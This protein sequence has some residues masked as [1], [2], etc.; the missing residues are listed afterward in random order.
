M[1]RLDEL[2]DGKID[3]LRRIESS[4]TQTTIFPNRRESRE[5]GRP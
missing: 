5:Q 2:I 3:F 4:Q 1:D